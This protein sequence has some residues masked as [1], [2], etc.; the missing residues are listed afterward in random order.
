[1][2]VPELIEDQESER[3][4]FDRF[5][6]ILRRRYMQFL[7]PFFLGWLLVWAASWVLPP[8]YK[9]STLIMVEQPTMPHEY[10]E[11]NISDD[12]QARVQSIKTQILSE[13]RLLIIIDRLHLYG[14]REDPTSTEAKVEQ[15]RK[16]IDVELDRDPQK[17]DVTAFRISF[18]AKTPQ[19]AQSATRELTDLFIS[20]N[21]KVRQQESEGTTT[22]FEKQLEDAR[23]NLAQQESKVRQ[24][25]SEHEGTLPTQQA[26]NL[27]ILSGLQARLQSE[28]D[29]LNDAKQQ[30]VYLQSLLEQQRAAISRTRP[31]SATGTAPGAPTDLESVDD[32]L[33]KLRAQLADLSS[34]YT[35]QYPDVQSAKRQI[36]KLEATR[37]GLIA[38][39]KSRSKDTKAAVDSSAST[40]EID[41]TLSIPAQQT[42]SQLQA[43]QLD[44]NNRQNTINNLNAKINDYQGRLNSVPGTEQQLADLTR[45]YDQSETNYND[46]L[47]KKEQS[48]MATSMEQMQ[49]GERFTV[50]DPPNFPTK[51]DFPNRLKFCGIGLGVGLALGLLVAGG[52]EFIDDRLHTEKEIQALLATA[53]ISE[54][55]E[56]MSPFDKQETRRNVRLGW[57]TAAVVLFLILA[58]SLF[59]YLRS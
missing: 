45:G 20:E 43:N 55:P 31:S 37:D 56:V 59:S 11:P 9:S 49:E 46:L 22:F 42:Q 1:M 47:K 18:T 21:N 36:A 52:S 27:E 58:G 41:T 44:I 14:G 7:L 50:L 24:Y 13:T 38:A 32:Q 10:V 30:R 33:E 23:E 17:Q 2:T 54:V 51:P 35:D 39:A 3:I 29:A 12:L 25:E 34:R 28:Q 53:V 16:D 8:R 19:V 5:I 15:M 57:A 40:D 48:E 4:D 26:S 6:G